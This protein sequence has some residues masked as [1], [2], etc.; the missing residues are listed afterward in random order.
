MNHMPIKTD[1]K[2]RLG[3]LARI[4]GD[5]SGNTIAM[6]AAGLI[7][8]TA[9]IGSGVDISRTYLVKSR[10]QQACDAGALA[11]RKKMANDAWSA[12]SY[13][14]RTA[15][16]DMFDA[17][18]AV[19]LIGTETLVR[20]Y[21]ES[22]GNVTGT[23][24]VE[25]PMVVMHMFGREQTDVAVTCDA[26]LAIPNTDV[27]FVLDTTGSMNQAEDGSNNQTAVEL[28]NSKIVG[29]RLAVRCFYEALSK[30]NSTADCGSTPS[31]VTRSTQV[32]FGFVPYAVN[33][34]VGRLLPHDY[35]VDS[36][37]YQSREAVE[38]YQNVV[39]DYQAGTPYL[40]NTSSSYNSGSIWSSSSNYSVTTPVNNSSACAALQPADDTAWSGT[41]GAPYGETSW[42]SGG[43]RITQWYTAEAGTGR[44]FS[45]SYNPGARRCTI[46]LR[47]RPA[48]KQRT[49]RRTDT[50]IY[51]SQLLFD[52]YEYKQLTHNV[53][54]LKNSD[55]VSWNSTVTL[56]VGNEGLSTSVD[57]DGCIEERQTVNGSNYYPIPTDAKDLDVDLIPTGD[58]TTR[59]APML[60][61]A[62]WGRYIGGASANTMATVSTS[63]NLNRN[64]NYFCPEEAKK[65]AT[66]TSSTFDAYV[67][68][69]TAAGNTYHDTGL[70]W[71]ARLISPTGLFAD[72]N[73]NMQNIQRHVVFMTDGD[74]VTSSQGY[75][76]YGVEWWDRRRTGGSSAP[77]ST[78]LNNQVN[79]RFLAMCQY[80]K[81][82]MG[83]TLWV[84][85]FGAGVS[86]T[87]QANLQTC[88]SSNKYYPAGDSAALLNAFKKI[89]SEIAD[90]RLTN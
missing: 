85:A 34:N 3:F 70:I 33:V 77:T 29:L 38:T 54:G 60:P 83:I 51:E 56:P 4:R 7:P 20:T 44:D 36:W 12:S 17:N 45:R 61:G 63:S 67:S 2:K 65:L 30:Q 49:Y 64:F 22:G 75:S 11:G 21:T 9:M 6:M 76:A 13:A 24:S 27:M 81:N 47:T 1:A 42:M 23:A 87:A 48:T 50:P 57:W 72:E 71:G 73:N 5:Q 37:A 43:D 59:W 41:E 88:A 55:G 26:E 82:D 35:M 90:L 15:A 32:R 78:A 58:T 10:L 16:N 31:G 62:V 8:L 52:H 40:Y 89:A 68:T 86:G 19:G 53:S 25:I 66:W 14:A 84:V 69:L 28:S 46:T 74:T 18:F 39:V 79:N 80:I